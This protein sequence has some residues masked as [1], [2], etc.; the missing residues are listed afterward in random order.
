MTAKLGTSLPLKIPT[1]HNKRANFKNLNF[2]R[3]IYDSKQDAFRPIKLH[4]DWLTKLR[5]DR[6]Q[7]HDTLTGFWYQLA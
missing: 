6:C 5:Y 7:A 4:A 2:S 1:S 3:K